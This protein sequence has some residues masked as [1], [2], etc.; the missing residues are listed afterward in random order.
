MSKDI[1]I[2]DLNYYI[3]WLERSII[4]EHINYYDYSEFKYVQHIGTG[5]YGSVELVSWKNAGHFFALKS[6]NNDKQTLKEVVKE[7]QYI[8]NCFKNFYS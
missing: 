5:A 3:D 6:F 1:R 8:Y 2:K 4:D 7:V